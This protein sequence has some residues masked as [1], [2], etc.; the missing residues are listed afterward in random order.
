L[1]GGIAAFEDE[2]LQPSTITRM[3]TEMLLP[4]PMTLFIKW[5]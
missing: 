2:S 4:T 3:R 1:S 5:Y